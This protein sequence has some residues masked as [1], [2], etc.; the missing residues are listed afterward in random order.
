MDM[1]KEKKFKKFKSNK[2]QNQ[3]YFW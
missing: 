2:T 1:F 3:Q